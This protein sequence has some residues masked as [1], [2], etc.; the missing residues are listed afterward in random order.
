MSFSSTGDA[1]G[2]SA[3]EDVR[4]TC[5]RCSFGVCVCFN[6]LVNFDFTAIGDVGGDMV[7]VGG[8]GNDNRSVEQLLSDKL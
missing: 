3:F 2:V 7:C 5:E 6:F 8:N 4:T 1:F